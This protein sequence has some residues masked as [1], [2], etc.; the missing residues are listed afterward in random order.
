M[1]WITGP[2]LGPKAL[3]RRTPIEGA[4]GG[5]RKGTYGAFGSCLGGGGGGG[6]VGGVVEEEVEGEDGESL[7]LA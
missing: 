5:P 7:D 1:N 6:G 4:P 2:S 3:T